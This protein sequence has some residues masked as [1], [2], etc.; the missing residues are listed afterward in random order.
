MNQIIS[1][2]D[3]IINIKE[4]KDITMAGMMNES[5]EIIKI[6]SIPKVRGEE[7]GQITSLA[8]IINV[9]SLF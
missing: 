4:K 8:E 2:D 9:L 6:W 5:D 7:N 3:H 1:T